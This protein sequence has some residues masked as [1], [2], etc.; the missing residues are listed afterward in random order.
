MLHIVA[1]DLERGVT[2]VIHRG[3][4]NKLSTGYFNEQKGRAK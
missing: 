4:L 1:P 2:K 3:Y